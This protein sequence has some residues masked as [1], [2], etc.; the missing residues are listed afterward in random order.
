MCEVRRRIDALQG[1]R[2]AQIAHVAGGTLSVR[3]SRRPMTELAPSTPTFRSCGARDLVVLAV[4]WKDCEI[5]TDGAWD[6]GTGAHRGGGDGTV[7]FPPQAILDDNL[8]LGIT[9]AAKYTATLAVRH[10]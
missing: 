7:T 8:A 9:S 5:R 10:Q 6:A 3:P 1:R 2:R 4:R